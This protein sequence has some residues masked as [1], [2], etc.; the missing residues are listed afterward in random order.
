MLSSTD[1]VQAVAAD[2]EKIRETAPLVLSLTNSVVQ[3][4]TANLLLAIG[5]VPAMLNDA[6]E[7]ADMLRNGTGA[8][9]VNLGTV[10]RE[11]GAVSQPAE[12]PLGDGSCGRRGA[13]PA[14]AAGGAIK[15]TV[16]PHH[17]RKRF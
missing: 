4:L 10:T 1:L 11:Q 16:S 5:A 2:L 9:L 3:P 15:G 13:L 14:H 17:P 6:E 12:Y 8:L 7:A